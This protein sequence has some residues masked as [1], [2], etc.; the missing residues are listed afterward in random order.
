MK[1]ITLSGL[2]IF[3]KIILANILSIITI[4]SISFIINA[5]FTEDIGYYGVGTPKDSGS[6]QE[7]LY[8]HYYKDGDD[9]K[10]AEFEEKGYVVEQRTI[11]SDVSAAGEA[12]FLIIGAVFT[13][14]M[15]ATILYSYMWKEG[16]KDLN[17]IRFGRATLDKYKGVKIGIVAIIPY[18]LALIALL[19]GKFSFAKSFPVILYKYINCSFFSLINVI[20]GNTVYIG[21]LAIWKFILLFVLLLLIPLYLGVAYYIGYKDILITDKLIYKKQK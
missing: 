11:R 21:D 3:G 8:T 14:S 20:C 17:L 10:L 16:N 13:L 7:V 18:L 12:A 15:L 4:I 9:T 2:K 5:A 1:N 19:I 6:K